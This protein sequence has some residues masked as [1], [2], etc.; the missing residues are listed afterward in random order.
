MSDL[1]TYKQNRINENNST[2]N[3][4]VTRLYSATVSNIRSVQNS[5]QSNNVKQN[6]VLIH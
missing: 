5:R 3:T 4:S 2:F 6:N 1:D